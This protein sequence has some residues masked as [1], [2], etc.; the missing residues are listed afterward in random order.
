MPNIR[1]LTP[2]DAAAWAAMRCALFTDGSAA[3]HAEEIAAFFAGSP[4]YFHAALGA[5]ADDGSAIGFAELSIRSHAEQCYS[6]RIAY[7]EGWYVHP[8]WRSR[9][10]GKALVRAAEEWGRA[11]GCTEF[12]SDADIEN[13]GSIAAH[14]ALGFTETDRVV[15]FR[16]DLV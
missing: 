10:V 9:G 8:A 15:T 12:G 7:L 5:F 4:K 14:L 16:R 11:A 1:P 6:G 3:E 2:G 13:S